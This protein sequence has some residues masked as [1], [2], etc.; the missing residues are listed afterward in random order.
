MTN[1]EIIVFQHVSEPKIR[2]CE[3][4]MFL[5]LKLKTVCYFSLSKGSEFA[6]SATN[7]NVHV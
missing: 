1:D 7:F 2:E 4:K 3:A 6:E 5:V